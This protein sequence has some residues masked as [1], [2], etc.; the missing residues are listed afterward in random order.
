MTHAVQLGDIIQLRKGKKALEVYDQRVNGAM[1]YIQIDEVRGVAPQ[2]YAHDAKGVIVTPV[3]LCIVWDGANAGT[4]GYGVDGLIG[5]TVA[6]MRLKAPDEWDTEFVGRLLQSKFRQINDE[7]QARGAT[8]P[9]VDKSKLEAI[10][11]PRIDRFE[12][13]RIATILATAD[14][15]RRR[16]QSALDH[17]DLLIKGEFVA[18]FGSPQKNEKNLQTA[19]ISA[20]GRVVTGNTPP[21]KD[22]ENYGDAIEWIKSDNINTPSHFLTPSTE[23]L[24]ERGRAIGRTAPAAS[25]LVTCIAGSP[26]A[27]GNAA[28][29]DREVAFNQQINA[30]I[31]HEG[32][33]P[34]FLYCQVLVGKPLIQAASTNSMKGMVSKRKFQEIEFLLPDNEKQVD[35][36]RFFSK[37]INMAQNLRADLEAS[38]E[39]F[40][41][42]TYRAFHGEL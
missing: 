20:F 40:L 1:P 32:T 26:S 15:I 22:P 34:Y 16:R 27:I 41:S 3:D 19:P 13:R 12:Q 35:F 31:P 6:R 37:A 10:V 28:L 7:A 2:K 4:V 24:T 38:E 11:I 23:R 29:T 33:D 9:H 21:R 14:G 17:I 25:T 5:S 39:L 36:G 42:L 8:I 30:I 18:R